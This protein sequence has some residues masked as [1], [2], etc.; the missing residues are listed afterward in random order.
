MNIRLMLTVS[1]F[2]IAL[3]LTGCNDPVAPVD[4]PT[5]KTTTTASVAVVTDPT[6]AVTTTVT[7]ETT[8]A[9][10]ATTTEAVT[11]TTGTDTAEPIH[12]V[13]SPESLPFSL[14]LPAS[15]EGRYA[16]R[17]DEGSVTFYELSNHQDSVQ[18]K[19]FTIRYMMDDPANIDFP[20]YRLLGQYGDIYAVALFPTD[21]QFSVE[22]A[23]AYQML[24]ADVSGILDTFVYTG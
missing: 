6:E 4:D 3:L 16:V 21:V 22:L 19:L 23:Q 20:S 8:E 2:A 17:E 15:W 9:T 7:E 18:G 5:A 14:T 1:I 10:T 13:T 11:T 12:F 24:E